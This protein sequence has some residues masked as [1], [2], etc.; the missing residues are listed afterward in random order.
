MDI[1]I[2]KRTT[3]NIVQQQSISLLFGKKTR[4]SCVGVELAKAHS[5]YHPVVMSLKDILSLWMLVTAS[6]VF[7]WPTKGRR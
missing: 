4:K 3:A 7:A 6:K 5:L 1:N 2:W